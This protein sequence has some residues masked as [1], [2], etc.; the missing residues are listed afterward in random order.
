MREAKASV[1]GDD[2][3]SSE[4]EDALEILEQA[5]ENGDE[6]IAADVMQFSLLQEDV[7]F[8]E[9]EEGAPAVGDVDDLAKILFQIAAFDAEFA[10]GDHVEGLFEE[11]GDSFSG[12][13]LAS[14]GGAVEDGN[15][16]LSFAC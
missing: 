14:A 15:E 8:V 2:T 6:G 13:G 10:D 9:Q 3:I 7:G 4:E 1:K 16:T 5:E 12:E 11:F